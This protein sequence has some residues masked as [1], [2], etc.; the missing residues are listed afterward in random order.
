YLNTGGR[1]CAQ[2]TEP[3]PTP[4]A[5]PTT[6]TPTPTA[7]ATATPTPTPTPTATPTPTPTPTVQVT[8]QTSPAG[9]TFSVAGTTYNSRRRF[10]WAAGSSHTIATTMPQSGGTGVQYVW[11][12]WSD[13]GAI[14]HSVAPTT[15]TTYTAT[16]G[17]QY[18]LTM[19]HNAAGR[20]SPNSGWKNSGE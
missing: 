12:K 6:P 5:T 2:S 20:V 4:T 17:T 15:N 13:H 16:F 3:T 1:Y 7:T 8:V 9:L 19:S 10:A 14:S 18:F 11:T